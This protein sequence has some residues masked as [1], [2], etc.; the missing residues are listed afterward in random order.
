MR[1]VCAVGNETLIGQSE[2]DLFGSGNISCLFAHFVGMHNITFNE[3]M[4]RYHVGL[5]ILSRLF[6]ARDCRVR[7]KSTNV[8]AWQMSY[9]RHWLLCL[10]SWTVTPSACIFFRSQ[11]CCKQANILRNISG[12]QDAPDSSKPWRVLS[13]GIVG[14]AAICDPRPGRF[15][16]V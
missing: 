13:L 14:Y 12:R 3:T 8:V 6:E 2:K 1:A 11:T 9:P 4:F 7:Q 15:L 5:K 16:G 10:A